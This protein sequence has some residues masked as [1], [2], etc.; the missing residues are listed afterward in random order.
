MNQQDNSKSVSY[1]KRTN[2]LVKTGIMVTL[3]LLSYMRIIDGMKTPEKNA[4]SINIT[5]SN[6]HVANKTSLSGS[7]FTN[8]LRTTGLTSTSRN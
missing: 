6:A 3:A 7:H 8:Y 1:R 2:F 5:A 4:P